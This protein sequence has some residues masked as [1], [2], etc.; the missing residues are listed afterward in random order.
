M[1]PAA[2]LNTC[3]YCKEPRPVKYLTESAITPG[4]LICR[5]PMP[6]IARKRAR[7]GFC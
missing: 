1:S 7:D 6:C 4:R 5:N 2:R 3:H